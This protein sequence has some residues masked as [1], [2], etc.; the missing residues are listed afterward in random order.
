M[1]LLV[2]SVSHSGIQV[3]LPLYGR[4]RNSPLYISLFSSMEKDT[5]A[6]ILATSY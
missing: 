1:R 5:V 2:T 3:G 4:E 6:H